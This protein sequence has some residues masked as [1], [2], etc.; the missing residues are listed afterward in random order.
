[1]F[2]KTDGAGNL[3]FSSDLPTTSFT[4]ATVE[5]SIADSDLVLIYDDS[6]T[7]VRKMTKANLVAGIGGGL[8]E[9][10][11]WRI[12]ANHTITYA[13]EFVTANWERVDT[14]GFDKIGTGMSQSS[15]V[16][17]FPSTGYWLII[18]NADFS[19]STTDNV[20]TTI[21]TTTDNST[22]SEASSG[23]AS[24]TA[25]YLSSA[26]CS[27]IFDVTNTTNCKVKFYTSTGNSGNQTL[28]ANTNYNQTHVTWIKL[29][30]T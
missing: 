15:G 26:S 12:S 16:F 19:F 11:Q 30:N 4:G 13:G 27:F 14:D 21:Y 17:T 20:G 24:A 18:Y 5:T 8:S 10:D 2:L 3:S 23:Y 25:G 1:L 6:A 22:Y 7:A 9:A 28:M 29:G